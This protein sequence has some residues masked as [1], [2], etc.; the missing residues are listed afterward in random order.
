MEA[1]FD[2]FK[3]QEGGEVLWVTRQ[4]DIAEAETAMSRLALLSPG[5]YFARDSRTGNV[6]A[7]AES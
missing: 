6:V 7:I 4:P 2:V 1:G 5:E 3:R